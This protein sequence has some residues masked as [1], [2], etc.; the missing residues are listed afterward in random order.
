LEKRQTSAKAGDVDQKSQL[1]RFKETA[2]QVET[3]DSEEAFDRTLKK[4]AK[5]PPA[6]KTG[7]TQK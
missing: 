6:S 1:E 3:D 2:K 7:S 5:A 4:V